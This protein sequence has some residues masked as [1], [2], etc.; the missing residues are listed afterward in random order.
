MTVRLGPA[1][2]N[3]VDLA[4]GN[5]VLY[6]LDATEGTV[7]AFATSGRDQAPTPDTLVLRA[8]T[9][10]D[11][12]GPLQTPV[13]MQ[14]VD[15]GLTVVDQ[16]RT[17]V[18]VDGARAAR[19][20]PLPR[21]ASWLELGAL[22][23]DRGAELFVL[24]SGAR[25]LLAYDLRGG[26]PAGEPRSV[27]DARATPTFPFD[28]AAEVVGV[29]DGIVVR[30]DEGTLRRF[31]LAGRELPITVRPPDG[32]PV[33]VQG[34]ATDRRGG[35][36]LADPTYGRILQTAAD[37]AFVR[38]LRDPALG[39]VRLIQSSPDGRRLYGLVATGVLAIDVP[40]DG[41]SSPILSAG[42][43]GDT[44]SGH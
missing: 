5:D 6:T 3:V 44:D 20:Q 21:S 34:L 42:S 2:G 30:L 23:T 40:T 19:A 36:Y 22:G 12:A 17:V 43:T 26:Q 14:L 9:A 7:R 37:G 24:D 1:G 4:V 15:G 8:G 18:R 25:Q 13:A 16:V 32:R 11:W 35:L 29:T 38:Q 41:P 28:H 27:L 31:D 39:G 10:G 33:A